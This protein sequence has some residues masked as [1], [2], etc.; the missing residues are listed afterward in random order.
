MLRAAA[1]TVAAV[2]AAEIIN[3][4]AALSAE[5]VRPAAAAAAPSVWVRGAADRLFPTSV[6]EVTATISLGAAKGEHEAAQVMVRSSSALSGVSLSTTA[7]TG[8]GGATIAA[9]QIQLRRQYPHGNVDAMGQDPIGTPTDNEVGPS[10]TNVYYDALLDNAPITVAANTT[11]P[12]HVGVRV[13]A[14]QT[15]GIYTGTVTVSSSG[16]SVSVPISVQVYNVSMPAPT[17]GTLKMNNWFTSAGWDYTGTQQSV[18]LQYG[19]S[20]YDARWWTVMANFAKNHALH[21]NNVIYADFQALLIPNTTI[22]GAGNYTFGWQTFDRFIQLFV[23]AGALKH[24]YTPTLLEWYNTKPNP[25][26]DDVAVNVEIL[27]NVN[28][29]TQKVLVAPGSATANAYLDKVLPALRAHLDAKGWTDIFYFSALDEPR[30]HIQTDAAAWLYGKYAQYFPNPHTAE[31][32]SAWLPANEQLI[33]TTAPLY[34]LYH[35]LVGP[36]QKLRLSGKELWLYNC[37]WP[38]GR[39]MNRFMR[40][41]LDKTRLIP[42]MLW[43]IGAT[44]YLHWGWNYWVDSN[45]AGTAFTASNTFDGE[46]TGDKWL[47]RPNKGAL[48]VYDSIRSEAQLDGIEDYELL[49]ALART[50][51]ATAYA[52]ANTLISDTQ[53]YTRSGEDVVAAHRHLLDALVSPDGDSRFPVVDGFADERNWTHSQGSWSVSGGGYNQTDSSANWG[54]TAA[55]KGRGYRDFVAS[56]DVLI[57]GVNSNGG[58]TNWA[59]MVIRSANASDMDSGYLI[60]MRRNGDVFVYR[61]GDPLGHAQMPGFTTASASRLKVVALGSTLTIC[62]GP[63]AIPFLTINNTGF[64]AGNLALVTGGASARFANFAVNPEVNYAEGKAVNVSTSHSADGWSPT[65]VVNG[66]AGSTSGALGWSSAGS[67]DPSKSE[68]IVVDCGRAYPVNRIDLTPR[69]D[70]ANA[71]LGFPTDFSIAVSPDNVTW[72]TILNEVNYPK[73]GAAVQT[74]TFPTRQIRAISVNATKL[75]AD[76]FGAYYFQLSQIAMYGENLA[77]GRPVTASSSYESPAEGW[78]AAAATD[79]SWLSALGTPM[80]WSSGGS[81]DPHH[82]EYLTVDLQAQV[83]IKDVTLYG[84]TDGGLTGQ[85]FPVNFEI[86]CSSDPS[87]STFTTLA[88]KAGYPTPDGQPQIFGFTPVTTRYV[89]V[90]VSQL[91]ADDHGSYRAQISEI[92]VH[93]A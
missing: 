35:D 52:V 48:D 40:F 58:D 38:Q 80:G 83:P 6:P 39:Y 3:P 59:G 65:A 16:G 36:Y 57:T 82:T 91:S 50:K 47:V 26:V 30:S 11:Q 23:D 22:D 46:Q 81:T 12:Y 24:I 18:P 55:L 32:H 86:R 79:G 89:R 69:T 2:G 76:Q 21:R 27:Q 5:T 1:A 49:T 64:T 31:A 67:T 37:I 60:A 10:G 9:S 51:P 74:F 19:C 87:F 45:Q 72:T 33:T 29:S 63:A 61:S 53:N 25:G 85:C 90:Q 41:H 43:K 71:G 70:G 14:D 73:P 15:A 42:W 68:A 66:Q 4:Q 7:L 56:V 28:G 62:G 93:A 8:P 84:R 44:G 34:S 77:L 20:M 88:S 75:T 13:P 54:Y 78:G 92:Q 17:Q